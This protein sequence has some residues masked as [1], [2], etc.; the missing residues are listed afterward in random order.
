[1]LLVRVAK[2][3]DIAGWGAEDLR[4]PSSRNGDFELSTGCRAGI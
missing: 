3:Q 1:M 4:F 2:E